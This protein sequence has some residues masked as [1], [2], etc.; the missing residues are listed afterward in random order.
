MIILKY[1]KKPGDNDSIQRA[2][3]ENLLRFV[4]LVPRVATENVSDFLRRDC[5]YK[6][7]MALDKLK[8]AGAE[9]YSNFLIRP[10]TSF[11]TITDS[12]I[13]LKNKNISLKVIKSVLTIAIS[14]TIRNDRDFNNTAIEVLDLLNTVKNEEE[15]RQITALFETHHSQQSGLYSRLNCLRLYTGLKKGN[16]LTAEN[17][18]SITPTLAN[19][20]LPSRT[21]QG[22]HLTVTNKFTENVFNILNSMTSGKSIER[23]CFA[24][25][26]TEVEELT[27]EKL[28]IIK[29]FIIAL[30]TREQFINANIDASWFR[31]VELL[32]EGRVTEDELCSFIE[33]ESNRV[34][35]PRHSFDK[36]TPECKSILSEIVKKSTHAAVLVELTNLP[37]RY[38]PI[39]YDLNSLCRLGSVL[40]K[41][42]P[43]TAIK[44]IN[45]MKLDLHGAARKNFLSVLSQSSIE[46]LTKDFKIGT[47]LFAIRGLIAL[48]ATK[49][50]LDVFPYFYSIIFNDAMPDKIDSRISSLRKIIQDKD[51]PDFLGADKRHTMLAILD[52]VDPVFMLKL[53]KRIEQG[54]IDAAHVDFIMKHRSPLDMYDAI[55]TLKKD[56]L[57][58]P[59][60]LTALSTHLGNIRNL[61]RLIVYKSR[62]LALF[63]DERI[64][65]YWDQSC[66]ELYFP[67]KM[68][69][70]VNLKKA[71]ILSIENIAA[72]AALPIDKSG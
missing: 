65:A 3:C 47:H 20:Q 34:I 11:D 72:I 42:E 56:N 55:E 66:N 2:D 70:L 30:E 35:F 52:S 51:F 54:N 32:Y 1:T 29:S 45:E 49:S 28:A 64:T 22:H 38:D 41:E 24:I 27:V 37:E 60:N 69:M 40:I 62:N 7:M 14:N 5:R 48:L 6:M 39:H 57:A 33:N 36:L 63:S 9:E 17:V 71:N 10:I 13:A 53:P 59:E 15:V 12:L 31:L 46:F 58:T 18:S 43:S 21:F 67:I 26:Y 61:A 68:I 4:Q 50:R 44:I 23:M 19:T 8:K 25:G 16:L